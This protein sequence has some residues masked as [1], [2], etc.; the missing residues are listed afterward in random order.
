MEWNRSLRS[1]WLTSSG[2][3]A[4]CVFEGVWRLAVRV[5]AAEAGNELWSYLW[6]DGRGWSL[7]LSK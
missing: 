4:V 7:V 1:V 2:C 3:L 5:T 6:F